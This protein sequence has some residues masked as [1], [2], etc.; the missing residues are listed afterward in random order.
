MRINPRQ[1][2]AFRNVMLSGSITSAAEMMNV[3]Q[4]AVSRLIRDFEFATELSLFDREGS[5]LLI[6][7][8]AIE[9]YREVER[10]YIGLDGIGRAADD[11][12]TAKGKALRM[13]AV[14]SLASQC[15]QEVVADL[16]VSHKSLSVVF[17]VES[18]A[19]VIDMM[20][21]H[22]YD[23]G[24]AFGSPRLAGLPVET[25][26]EAYA[27]A[28][29]PIDH[30]FAERDFITVDML[31]NTRLLLPGRKT[32]LRQA[33]DAQ[34]AA[35]GFQ[36]SNAIE[37]SIINC[38]GLAAR[39]TGVAI[40]DPLIATEFSGTLLTRRIE[41]RI[42]VTYVAVRPPNAPKSRLLESII[43]DARNAITKA[44]GPQ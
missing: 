34:C 42:S 41:P 32:P 38:C 35:T 14:P 15:L 43:D 10:L 39:G 11:I 8:E 37:T 24:F 12:R 26:A 18:T 9:L 13:V 36:I 40:V 20:T 22:Q 4:P 19:F 23:L 7:A 30:E 2:E 3:T 21:S 28:A 17:D 5:R 31:A 27:V 16:A 44:L 33:L 1:V 6:R 25:L 29:F